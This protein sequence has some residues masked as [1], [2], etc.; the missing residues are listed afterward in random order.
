MTAAAIYVQGSRLTCDGDR[1]A[2]A[3][4]TALE[5]RRAGAAGGAVDHRTLGVHAARV[6]LAARVDTLLVTA[7]EPVARALRVAVEGAGG[8]GC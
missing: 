8:G 2:A 5:A 7:D 4:R 1:G 6:T 3:V